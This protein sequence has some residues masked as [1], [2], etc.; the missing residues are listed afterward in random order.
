M[1]REQIQKRGIPKL[2]PDDMK[3][4][5]WQDIRRNILDVFAENVYGI[6]PPPPEA[7][8]GEVISTDN[9]A[10]AGKA[11]HRHINIKFNTPRGEF[12]FP[13][14]SL[15][16]NKAGKQPM[17]IFLSFHHYKESYETPLEE[18]I[19]RGY[20]ITIAHYE[21]IT[22][23]NSDMDD[24]LAGRF[25]K[26]GEKNEWGKIGIWAYALS[27]VMDYVRTLEYIDKDRIACAGHSRLGKT[28]LWCGAQ[29]ERF[30]AVF[31]NN[32]GCS[33]AAVTRGKQG[34]TVKNICTKYAYWFCENY[35]KYRENENAM[36]FDQHQLVAAVAPRLFY[37]CSAE[38]DTW[39]DPE[40]EYLS[41]MLADEAYKRLDK[42]G[43]T[44]EDRYPAAGDVFNV[45]SIGYH[46]RSGKH[47]LSR[48]D[49]QMFLDFLDI[50]YNQG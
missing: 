45:G 28:A 37:T 42:Y 6:T 40:S 35:K 20:G 19:D 16:P 21:K 50:H 1:L 39:A 49:W 34:E 10:F 24:G 12:S 13:V 33:G 22:K 25:N 14:D 43:F 48:Y 4:H 31:A 7:T 17:I 2:I 15:V 47:F 8:Q 38:D 11:T 18:I 5:E 44:G 26:T 23:D 30:A 36:P 29:D 41:C 46:L 32:S 9:I 27:R 3:P